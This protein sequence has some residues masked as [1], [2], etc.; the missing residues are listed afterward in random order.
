MKAA[1]LKNKEP[2]TI[3][4]ALNRIWIREGPG[5]P[6]KGWFCDNGGK[7]QNS[8]MMGVISLPP[9]TITVPD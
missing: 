8:K 9:V 6:S 4:E 1:D 7:F 3:L 2:G 5:H